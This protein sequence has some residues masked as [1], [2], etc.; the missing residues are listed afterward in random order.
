MHLQRFAANTRGLRLILHVMQIDL[1][2][3]RTLIS[4]PRNS[5]R[6]NKKL[7]LESVGNG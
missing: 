4:A 1:Y 7:Q 5:L 3:S 6:D 2:Q